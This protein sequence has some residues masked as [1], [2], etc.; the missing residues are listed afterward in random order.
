MTAKLNSTM[1]QKVDRTYRRQ[2]AIDA[3]IDLLTG[4]FATIK[5]LADHVARLT[6]EKETLVKMVGW[7]E[8]ERQV[9]AA[10]AYAAKP[11]RA[12]PVELARHTHSS[13]DA[14]I[15]GPPLSAAVAH[16][17]DSAG[18]RCMRC[19]CTREAIEASGTLCEHPEDA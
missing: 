9:A 11:L 17:Y 19:S 5:C 18:K 16:V 12:N 10:N 15:T 1:A 4:Q 3:K 14:E 8:I 2:I 13:I 6:R 7:T